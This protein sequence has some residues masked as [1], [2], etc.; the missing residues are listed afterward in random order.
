MTLE[1]RHISI[2]IERPV[3]EVYVYVSDPARLP[4][5]AS[6]LSSGISRVGDR[7]V[8]DSPMG[9]VEVEFAPANAFGVADHT[10][11]LPTSEVFSNP[12]RVIGNDGGS[13]VVFT[14]FR[15]PGVSATDFDRDAGT[16]EADLA[17]LKRRL[18]R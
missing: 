5:W 1:T 3:A 6:G 11:T 16:V 17:A 10:V 9:R 12:L 4:E 18:E 15:M 8:A 7:W 13:E 2:S 14:L